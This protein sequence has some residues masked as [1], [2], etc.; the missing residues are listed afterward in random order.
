MMVRNLL[1]VILCS[2]FSV[3]GYI[4]NVLK[5]VSM[6]SRAGNCLYALKAY[7][8]DHDGLLAG[9][10]KVAFQQHPERLHDFSQAITGAMF[11]AQLR[12]MP[13]E[14]DA[15]VKRLKTGQ[16]DLGD[17]IIAHRAITAYGEAYFADGRLVCPANEPTSSG[18]LEF[19]PHQSFL[20]QANDIIDMLG[21]EMQWDEQKI[22]QEQEALK[23][24]IA[25]WIE[26]YRVQAIERP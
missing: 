16:A 6:S 21:K 19:H 18:F 23:L 20:K 17:I 2:P 22:K 1:F 11:L 13:N 25:R 15:S 8:E 3:S 4:S 14:I 5:S 26:Q 9:D 24:S 12:P 7:V 10:L